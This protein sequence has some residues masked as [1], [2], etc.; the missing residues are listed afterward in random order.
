[1]D[2]KTVFEVLDFFVDQGGN[3][4]DTYAPIKH[5]LGANR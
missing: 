3:F 5:D 2:K 1:M 4:L